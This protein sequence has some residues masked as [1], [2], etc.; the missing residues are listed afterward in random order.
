MKKYII[1]YY[2]YKENKNYIEIISAKNELEA[3]SVYF[4]D[5]GEEYEDITYENFIYKYL[6]ND[7]CVSIKEF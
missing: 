5:D 7:F 3:L 6:S 2:S 1:A 4:F